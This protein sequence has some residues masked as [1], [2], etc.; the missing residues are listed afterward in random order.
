MKVLLTG[1]NGFVGSHVLDSLRARGIATAV[2]LRPT[3]DPRFIQA[4]RADVEVRIGS[5]DETRS[6]A[7]AM[8][9]ITH[10]IH[11]AGCTKAVRRS[12]FDRVNHL[13]TR[14]VV[15]AAS[16][17]GGRI[18]R[19]VYMSSLAAGGPAVPETPA[20]ES[21]PPHPVSEYGRSKL[22]GEQEVQGLRPAEYVILRPPA[23]Y[24]PRDVEFL[25][26]FKTIQRHLQPRPNRQPL[27]LVF[28]QDLAGATATC[29]AHPAA[30]GKTFYVASPEVLT[31]RGLAQEIAAQADTWTL[32]LPLPPAALGPLCWLQDGI[33][34]LTGRP[35]LLSRQKWGELRAPG[36]VCDPTRLREDLGFECTTKLKQGI[37][38]TL[39]WYRQQGWL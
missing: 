14:H 4:H 25:R 18:Q 38:A 26:L 5:I 15:E 6:L 3:S 27:S 2:L 22:A 11:C 31:A 39:A 19:L 20:R 16:Q 8:H 1:A 30:A 28:V 33:S 37:A 17:Q 35:N 24:G 29:L 32:P 9:D 36:W 10:V 34:W 12:E 21:D 23:V 13:G 7:A